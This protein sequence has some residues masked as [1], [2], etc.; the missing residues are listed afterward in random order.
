VAATTTTT[1]ATPGAVSVEEVF[2]GVPLLKHLSARQL[3]R[4]A[5]LATR[6]S[7][8]PG[9]VIVRGSGGDQ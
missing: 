5:R 7:Y 4:L 9:A 6:R 1:S 3:S 2:A 8:R